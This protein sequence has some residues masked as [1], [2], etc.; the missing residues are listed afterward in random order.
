MNNDPYRSA[1]KIVPEIIRLFQPRSVLDVGCGDG[2]WLK[3]F[4]E[5]GV[6]D[7]LGIDSRAQAAD[8]LVIPI[9]RYLPMDLTA[10]RSLDRKFDIVTSFETAEHLRRSHAKDFVHF[11]TQHSNIIVFSSAAAGQGGPHHVNERNPEYWAQAFFD[12]GYEAF[13]PIRLSLI[14]DQAISWQYR[15]NALVYIKSPVP[16]EYNYLPRFN[17]EFQLT[18]SRVARRR[19]A[20]HLLMLGGAAAAVGFALGYLVGGAKNDED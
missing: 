15:Q 9:D 19:E 14:P 1:Q 17:P 4:A 3:A 18:H 7:Y 12:E 13:D 11:L 8:E 10:P 6:T 16:E 5:S 20:K 2:S